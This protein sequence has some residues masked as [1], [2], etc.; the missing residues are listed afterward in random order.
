MFKSIDALRDLTQDFCHLVRQRAGG[1]SNEE[2]DIYLKISAELCLLERKIMNLDFS[3]DQE[4][5]KTMIVAFN[6]FQETTAG[7]TK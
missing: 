3:Q 7:G 2:W 5:I 1:V 6:R 4:Q